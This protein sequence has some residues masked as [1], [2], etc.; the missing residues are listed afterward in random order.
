MHPTIPVLIVGGGPVGLALAADL[1]WRGIECHLVE[2]GDGTIFHPRANTINSRTMEFCR[3]WGIAE[4][5]RNSGTPPDFPLD[6]VYATGLQGYE[7]A[8]IARP[9]YGG[10]KP[11]PTTPERSQRCNQIFFDPILRDLA[12]SFPSV[13][14]RYKC[15]LE[16][17]AETSDGVTVTIR[18]LISDKVETIAAKYLVA[19]CGGRS[20]VPRAL[21]VQWEGTPFL[22]YHLNV[23]LRIPELWKHHDKGK[24]AFY[25]FVDREGRG[26]SLIEIDGD[27]L[28][29]LGLNYGNERVEP[30]SVDIDAMVKRFLGPTVPYEVI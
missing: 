24:T 15:R 9:T 17:F 22:S 18:D 1:G 13:T 12:S 5:V 26:P 19:C 21:G 10:P 14:L 4:R 7:V 11:I 28:W 2:Q 3:R 27:V 29:R 16:S 8:R 23:F 6:I 20:P 25:F 30:E